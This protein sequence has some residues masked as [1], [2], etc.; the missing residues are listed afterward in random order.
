MSAVK[1]AVKRGGVRRIVE[2]VG[3]AHDEV[4]LAA[5][6]HVAHERL[7]AGQQVLDLGLDALHGS[8]RVCDRYAR[9]PSRSARTPSPSNR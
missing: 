4:E 2:H 8:R 7:H 3:S 9:S 6:V 1:I 5:L